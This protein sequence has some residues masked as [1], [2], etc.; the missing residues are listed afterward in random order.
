MFGLE[1]TPGRG[2]LQYDW[3]EIDPRAGPIC[4]VRVEIH[5]RVGP[6]C[7]YRVRLYP[8]VKPTCMFVNKD[9]GKFRGKILEMYQTHYV[10]LLRDFVAV[11]DRAKSSSEF[12]NLDDQNKEALEGKGDS[13]DVNADDDEEPLFPTS[14]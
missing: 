7:A 12:Q 6:I 8:R 9:Y 1:H 13:D 2:S 14:I 5:P 3:V 10:A 4:V 11:E